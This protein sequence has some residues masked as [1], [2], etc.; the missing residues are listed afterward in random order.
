MRPLYHLSVL[1]MIDVSQ[2]E[3]SNIV[4]FKS[5]K[6]QANAPVPNLARM[7]A[8]LHVIREKA[9]LH[10]QK[11]LTHF[12]N[13]LDDALF[14]LAEKA[15]SN[16]DQ[17]IYFDS[18]REIR[19]GRRA[20]EAD[21]FL[22]MDVA[23][24][25]LLVAETPSDTAYIVEE[26]SVIKDEELEALVA[27]DAMTHRA[28]DA[29]AHLLE[30]L[31]ARIG[32]LVPVK[33]YQKNNPI[34]ANLLCDAF[35]VVTKRLA[36]DVKAK[37]VL[38]KLFDIHVMKQ[39]GVMYED[40]N[41]IMVQHQVLPNYQLSK[42][43]S[44]HSPSRSTS[45][46]SGGNN[47]Q[48]TQ[49]NDEDLLSALRGLMAKSNAIGHQRSEQEITTDALFTALS[50]AQHQLEQQAQPALNESFQSQ[51][52]AFIA[53]QHQEKSMSAADEDVINL[54][55]MMFEFILDDR[56]LASAMKALLG[57][58]QIPFIKVAIVDPTFF[59][60]GGHPAR[61][62]LNEMAS[63]CLGWQEPPQEKLNRDMLYVKFSHI[64]NQII[65]GFDDNIDLFDH[66]LLDLRVF[67]E[68]E[69]R[70]I[71]MLE[72]RIVDAE[73]GKARA[74]KARAQVAIVLTRVSDHFKLNA[75]QSEAI[76][77]SFA[78]LLFLHWVRTG[79]NGD[80]WKKALNKVMQ[81]AFVMAK[82]VSS[83]QEKSELLT[84]AAKVIRG[85]KSEFEIF[86]FDGFEVNKI[87]SRLELDINEKIKT[88]KV[89]SAAHP[90]QTPLETP[91]SHTSPVDNESTITPVSQVA[92][93]DVQLPSVVDQSESISHCSDEDLSSDDMLSP[94]LH[95]LSQDDS[96]EEKH[97]HEIVPVALNDSDNACA[98]AV[99]AI[100]ANS[101]SAQHLVLV[102]NLSMGTWFEV[103]GE[104][105]ERYRCRL[106]AVIKSIGK[107]IFVNRAGTKV[108]EETKDSLAQALADGRYTILDDGMLFD[109]A[110]ESVITNLRAQRSGN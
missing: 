64:V 34:G 63:A 52:K 23:F 45:A 7:S 92:D 47:P 16:H 21:Y 59:N 20:L 11:L 28:N 97:E 108:A 107:Y 1:T 78:N 110:L 80:A 40:L 88:A 56:N 53:Q 62:L 65:D 22:Q 77:T 103:H 85:I 44:S 51:L 75:S 30:P 87:I 91:V 37:L 18:M 3:S 5:P 93:S 84:L 94:T 10:L 6:S 35:M 9:R 2:R 66:L 81:L 90:K 72:Q 95:E 33:V 69:Q 41:T 17:N 61:K 31:A 48:V 76:Q 74:E 50:L 71:K 104:N 8:P 70:R 12:F 109:R 68:K 27:C 102:N 58:L 100:A 98:E 15:L 38:Y 79:A 42:T 101:V 86:A 25:Q 32:H 14:E 73:D 19:L 4:P 96:E 39:L 55:G 36:I 26:L 13:T 24:S 89:S 106:A 46:V 60:K 57:R 54:V 82:P 105:Q 43:T 99:D 29:F 83:E 49:T 67:V